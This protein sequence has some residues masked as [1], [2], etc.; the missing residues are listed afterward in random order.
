MTRVNDCLPMFETKAIAFILVAAIQAGCSLP[1]PDGTE[2][3][4]AARAESLQPLT[5]SE[6]R[7]IKSV[8]RNALL[9]SPVVREAAS[10]IRVSA[11][12]VRIQR[13]AIF[14]SLSLSVGG[15]IGDAG[16]GDTTIALTGRQLVAG[17][18][19]TERQVTAAD[20][21]LQMNYV[22]FQQ[23]VDEAMAE[24]L[25]TYDEVRTHVRVLEV[26]RQ[27]L[28][29]LRELQTLIVRRHE[30][31]AAPISDVLETRKRLQAA[32]FLVLD[33]ELALA[34]ARERLTQLSGQPR[35]G[36]IPVLGRET[37]ASETSTDALLLA[38]LNL[39]KSQIELE[40]AENA[41][42]PSTFIEPIVRNEV[43]TS[44]LGFGLNLGINSDLL[45]GG[46]LSAAVN[47]ARN[48]LEA[49]AANVEIVRR[50]D[51]IESGRLQREM[52]A[53]QQRT[54]MLDRQISLLAQTRALY[55]DQYFDL[56]TRELS[57]LLDNEEEYYSRKAELIEVDSEMANNRVTC[58]ILERSLRPAVG[59]ND[60]SIYGY[61]L[62]K[63]VFL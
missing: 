29:A 37:C 28:S 49:A 5:P 24:M 18:G 41:R 8:S 11:D 33:T 39:V 31:G 48:T 62:T 22:T 61:P 44:S 47:A 58:A 26:W 15:G 57:E 13:A 46:A 23:S 19:Q 4:L 16:Q 2:A 63:T 38:Q 6:G 59:I 21:E 45:Q 53:A 50:D 14:P 51:T 20:I 42:V 40:I 35:G 25:E 10:V 60:A 56:G 12:E 27:Q 52:A 1:E 55:R 30:I 32:E 3:A 9:L 54:G 17:F 36:E 34:E 43:G 7:D